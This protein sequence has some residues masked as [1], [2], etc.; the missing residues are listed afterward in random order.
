MYIK[1]GKIHLNKRKQDLMFR[2]IDKHTFSMYDAPG[3]LLFVNHKS[4]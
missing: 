4:I 3:N 1:A 2:F